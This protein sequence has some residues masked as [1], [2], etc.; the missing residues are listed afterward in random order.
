MNRQHEHHHALRRGIEAGENL[1]I[2]QVAIA[3][4][5]IGRSADERIVD[6][7]LAERGIER[8]AGQIDAVFRLYLAFKIGVAHFAAAGKN[9]IAGLFEIEHSGNLRVILFV[10]GNLRGNIGFGHAVLDS[11]V[12]M[13]G[14][15][16]HDFH[17]DQ[18]I[19]RELV[20]SVHYGGIL[21][22][23]IGGKV[24]CAEHDNTD[25]HRQNADCEK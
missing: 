15:R 5:V 4:I 10:G 2:K 23:F 8:H 20:H 18:V 17:I 1:H 25:Q 11:V 24:V 6:L 14:A 9:A 21:L 7:R 19:V 22:A 13:L 3:F 12:E 16:V